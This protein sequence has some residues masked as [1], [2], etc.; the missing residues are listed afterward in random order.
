MLPHD[1][2][3]DDEK[4]EQKVL[5]VMIGCVWLSLFVIMCF[6]FYIL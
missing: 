3:D 1:D 2:D 4:E 6:C 5:E